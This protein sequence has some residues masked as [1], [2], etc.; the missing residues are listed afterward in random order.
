MKEYGKLVLWLD[1]F[2]S[3][4]SRKQGRKLPLS[5]CVRNPSF[6][7]LIKALEQLGYRVEAFRAKHP[8]RNQ[9]PSGY[10]VI[11]KKKRKG[12]VLKEVAISLAKVRGEEKKL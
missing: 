5:K 4:L 8:K 10:V 3:N 1:Y 7:E 11:D 6:E 2:D 12:E 9:L